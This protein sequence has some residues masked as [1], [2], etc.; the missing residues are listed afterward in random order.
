MI[1]DPGRKKNS[2]HM[3]TGGQSGIGRMDASCPQPSHISEIK[4]PICGC[5]VKSPIVLYGEK[6]CW[7]CRKWYRRVLLQDDYS[8]SENILSKQKGIR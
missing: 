8:I 1:A 3:R 2:F 5:R 6:I 4:C 7:F